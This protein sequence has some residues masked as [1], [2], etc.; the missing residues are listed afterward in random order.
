[1][2]LSSKT[3]ESLQARPHARDVSDPG[4]RGLL[5]RVLPWGT[6][7]WLFRY[8]WAG[9][10]TRISLGSFP[11]RTLAEA[12]ELAIAFRRMLQRGIDPR[13]SNRAVA[14]VNRKRRQAVRRDPA[15]TL[16]N[17]ATRNADEFDRL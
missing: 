10:P 11:D 9:R 17:G 5:I 3:V 6:K 2:R 13:G 16:S 14:G 1:M 4:V 12:R 7:S 8:R 15:G